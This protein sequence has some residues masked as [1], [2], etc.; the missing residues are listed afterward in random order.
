M[1]DD[2]TCPRTRLRMVGH[3][4]ED[5]PG[6]SARVPERMRQTWRPSDFT[7]PLASVAETA[8]IAG[9]RKVP[10]FQQWWND[11]TEALEGLGYQHG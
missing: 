11:M 6:K 3:H 9:L 4:H 1:G 5:S 10:A 8:G 7:E 2:V